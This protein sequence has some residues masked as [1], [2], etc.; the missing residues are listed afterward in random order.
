MLFGVTLLHMVVFYTWLVLSRTILPEEYRPLFDVD[1]PYL[2]AERLSYWQ[3]ALLGSGL[4]GTILLTVLI[5]TSLPSI[6]LKKYNT[7]YF[8]HFLFIPFL[9]LVCV[10]A[11]TDFYL[12]LPGLLTWIVDG[13]LRL[14]DVKPAHDAE[15]VCETGDYYT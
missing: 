9:F 10:H 13:I 14:N 6:R 12:A 4:A 5:I 7:F 8:T 1:N 2:E 3:A 15:L 11:S